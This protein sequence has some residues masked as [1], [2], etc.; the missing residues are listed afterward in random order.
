MN[1]TNNLKL[2]ISTDSKGRNT[3][4]FP[5]SE[6]SKAMLEA[7]KCSMTNPHNK[8]ACQLANEFTL[9]GVKMAAQYL[10]YP[11]MMLG[12]DRYDRGFSFFTQSYSKGWSGYEQKIIFERGFHGGKKI[13]TTN[14][15]YTEKKMREVFDLCLAWTVSRKR[16]DSYIHLEGA[17]SKSV[18]KYVKNLLSNFSKD[19][20]I[21]KKIYPIKVDESY[22]DND[23]DS[24]T[25]I[26]RTKFLAKVNIDLN[27]NHHLTA[28]EIKSLDVLEDTICTI[29]LPFAI[30][31]KHRDSGIVLDINRLHNINVI[32]RCSVI[33][34]VSTNMQYHTIQEMKDKIAILENQQIAKNCMEVFVRN[35]EDE[36]KRIIKS[37]VKKAE[38][39]IN[40]KGMDE[41]TLAVVGLDNINVCVGD[42]ETGWNVLGSAED[43]IDKSDRT[44]TKVNRKAISILV[45]GVHPESN[46][47]LMYCPQTKLYFQYLI[48]NNETIEIDG[49]EISALTDNELLIL[50]IDTKESRYYSGGV[51][52][53]SMP[54]TSYSDICTFLDITKDDEEIKRAAD[55]D[56]DDGRVYHE[57]K[58]SDREAMRR[59]WKDTVKLFV[60]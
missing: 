31:K 45:D 47:K 35:L 19:F 55:D 27:L 7:H 13:L 2:I 10:G 29:T 42:Y 43:M 4:K 51:Q 30:V 20:D 24:P 15:E 8:H 16:K 58:D 36:L 41:N 40:N 21:I 12:G 50:G 46:D 3:F 26:K 9:E 14:K 53:I 28:K 37:S 48:S 22:N 52:L 49:E 60:E 34:K 18:H 57:L 44:T 17:Y 5:Y 38:N 11:S 23:Y 39:L 32:Q 6:T 33:N 59:Y 56:G 25:G 54:K 1:N